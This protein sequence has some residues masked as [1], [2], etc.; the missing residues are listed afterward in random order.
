MLDTLSSSV[1]RAVGVNVLPGRSKI[2][3]RVLD[4]SKLVVALTSGW[5]VDGAAS[6]LASLVEAD[7]EPL[8]LVGA[9]LAGD[10]SEKAFKVVLLPGWLTEVKRSGMLPG[11]GVTRLCVSFV[12]DVAFPLAVT[13]SRLLFGPSVALVDPSVVRVTTVECWVV[14]D[15]VRGL[16]I[17]SGKP[18][19]VLIATSVF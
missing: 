6:S 4:S 11:A 1:L 5:M 18:F 8:W 9:S 17:D 3:P 2:F 10:W 15:V 16:V 7:A 14:S 19:S 12:K 13:M